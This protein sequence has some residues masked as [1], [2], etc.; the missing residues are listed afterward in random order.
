[1]TADPRRV[2]EA[3]FTQTARQYA[4]S[5]IALRRVQSEALL[6]LTD[7]TPEDRLLDVACGPGALL[8]VFAPHVR[9]AVGLDLT[10]AMLREA[11]THHVEA[12]AVALVRAEAE[13][14]PFSA[15]AFTLVLTTWAVHHFGNPRRVIEEM[16][17]VCRPGGRV[18]IEDLVGDED[19]AV[20]ARQNEIER[21][22]DP[23]HV[24]LLS[25]RGLRSLLTSSG[26]TP[27][28][29]AEGTLDREFD[30][31][32]RIAGTPPEVALRVRDMLLQARPGDLGAMSPVEED[33]QIRF[34]HHWVVLV[35]RKP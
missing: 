31:W 5:R 15:G 33:G 20:R 19:D 3:R 4:A 17:R 8:S 35:A 34:R 27:V 24:A 12:G 21:Q 11:Q 16:F 30:E 1:V 23:A 9:H 14:M 22:R 2:N 32:C 28:G 29:Q 13:R 25:P 7:P 18:A 26:L 10:M 6:R